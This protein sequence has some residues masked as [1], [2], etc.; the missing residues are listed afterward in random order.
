MAPPSRPATAAPRDEFAN[1]LRE[2]L[3][4]FWTAALFA[5]GVNILFL[6][7]PIYLLQIYNRV[8]PSGSIPTLLALSVAALIAFITMVMLD[9]IR[10]RVLIRA[11]ARMDRL[12][13]GRLFHAVVGVSRATGPTS[14]NAQPLRDFDTFRG[15]M[16]GPA[17]QLFFDAPWSPLFLLI[18]YFLHPLLGAIGTLGALLLL[19]LAWLNDVLTRED[20]RTSG[21]AAQRSYV[22]AES[23]VRF[24]DPAQAM[25]MT[26]AL[27]RRWRVDRDDMMVKQGGGS[28][29]VAD[30]SALIRFCRLMLQ[31]TVMGAG[32]WLVIG[33]AILPAS[34]FAAALLLGRA[35]SPLEQ[36]VVG[37]RSLAGAVTAGRN[38][39]KALSAAPPPPPE[40]TRVPVRDGR[41][42]VEKAVFTP[43]GAKRPALKGVSLEIASGEA[44][45]VVGPSGAGKSSLA[46]LLV[47][48]AM[49]TSGRV[50]VGGLPTAQW[51]PDMLSQNVGYLPQSVGLFPGTVRQNIARFRDVADHSVLEAARRANVHDMILDFPEGYDTLIGEGGSGLSGGQRQRIALARALFGSPRLLVLDEPNAH[52]DSDGEEAL[53]ASIRTLKDHGSTI[54]IVA[55]RLGALA[56][57]DRVLMLRDGL[58]EMDGP[59]EEIIDQVPVATIEQFAPELARA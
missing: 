26:D 22:F 54:L 17:A 27:N 20:S 15:A 18:L 48:A 2:C 51:T 25:G 24:A 59:R 38:V 30:F 46:R 31:A 40:H 57:V 49:P 13:S 37:W 29:R 52:L 47:A 10:A 8:V 33:G 55:H 42:A 3:P 50:T 32:A 44:V 43:K 39:Q 19:G 14:R 23:V 12:L 35:L 21:E 56:E 45:G 5:G 1:A 36:A 7:S 6:A 58:L 28:D 16:A 41:V 53:A 11:A 9:A 4:L 34:I